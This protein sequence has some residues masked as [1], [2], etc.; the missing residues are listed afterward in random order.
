M[1]LKPQ[2]IKALM[3]IIEEDFRAGLIA[4]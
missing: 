4:P 3:G 2:Q 1:G